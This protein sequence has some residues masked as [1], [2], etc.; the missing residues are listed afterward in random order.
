VQS[1]PAA[2]LMFGI[3]SRVHDLGKSAAPVQILVP[4][5]QTGM[6]G[7]NVKIWLQMAR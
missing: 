6:R 3:L 4:L 2:F 5:G 7:R 1:R